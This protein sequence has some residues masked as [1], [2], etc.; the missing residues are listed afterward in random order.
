VLLVA[1][2]QNNYYNYGFPKGKPN[3]GETV[4]IAASREVNIQQ[5][6][7]V[8][9]IIHFSLSQDT[10]ETGRSDL[11]Y[12]FQINLGTIIKKKP[13]IGPKNLSRSRVH[14]YVMT[15]TP[16]QYTLFQPNKKEILVREYFAYFY[17]SLVVIKN[18]QNIKLFFL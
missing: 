18:R 3:P 7:V 8:F 9:N 1:Y 2:I 16:C 4:R 12:M 6:F 10:E 13:Y 15:T 5:F 11:D 17:F 14:Y